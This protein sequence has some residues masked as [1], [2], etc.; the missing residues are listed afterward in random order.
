MSLVEGHRSQFIGFH[1]S[2]PLM[3]FPNRFPCLPHPGS[4]IWHSGGSGYTLFLLN[5]GRGG[6]GTKHDLDNTRDATPVLENTLL[7][8][9][10]VPS[11]SRKHPKH[12]Q[13]LSI[14]FT[15]SAATGA[16]ESLCEA[17]SPRRKLARPSRER[18]G[19]KNTSLHQR[20]GDTFSQ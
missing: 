14:Q 5:I 18:D 3:Q 7:T 16:D 13:A 2:I 17:M 19:S 4:F 12:P 9:V 8:L 1:V 11:T 10:N 15:I 6:V 20:L